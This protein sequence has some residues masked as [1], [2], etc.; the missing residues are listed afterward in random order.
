MSFFLA[1]DLDDAART[2]ASNIVD[3]L[4]STTRA[5]WLPPVKLHLTLH[6]LGHPD[7]AVRAALEAPVRL[8]ATRH[9]PFSLRLE[10]A[11]TFTTARAPGV[12]WLGVSGEL[13]ALRALQR[14]VVAAVNAPLDRD[15]VPHVT[16]ARADDRPALEQLAATLTTVHTDAF[17]IRHI[18]LY[19]SANDIYR[20]CFRVPLGTEATPA[21]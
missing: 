14:D 19:E 4:K 2:S 1:V 7:A 21:R 11:G 8:A 20:V 6:F 9:A 12:L 18:T 13:D 5:K 17:Q 3:R 10:G 16:L 15:F